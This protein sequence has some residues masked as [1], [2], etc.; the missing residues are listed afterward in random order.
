MMG[1]WVVTL[2]FIKRTGGPGPRSNVFSMQYFNQPEDMMPLQDSTCGF[3]LVIVQGS[4]SAQV[5]AQV[6]AHYEND[7]VAKLLLYL[8]S[9]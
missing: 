3:H 8:G 9:E 7:H 4:H 2:R 5:S 1:V 6:S